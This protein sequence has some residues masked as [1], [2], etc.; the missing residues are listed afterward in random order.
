MRWFKITLQ[1]T[2]LEQKATLDVSEDNSILDA[3]KEVGL[4]LP[5]PCRT[6]SCDACVGRLLTGAVDQTEQVFLDDAQIAEGYAMLCCSYALS[7]CTIA[8]DWENGVLENSYRFTAV[9]N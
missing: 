8:I 4:N 5:L 2:Q 3:A 7:D 1:N 9:D 6:G